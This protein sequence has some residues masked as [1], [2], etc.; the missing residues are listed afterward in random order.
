MTSYFNNGTEFNFFKFLSIL[1]RYTG[2]GFHLHVKTGNYVK[3]LSIN[4]QNLKTELKNLFPFTSHC[5]SK[6]AIYLQ[7]FISE[8][9]K[10]IY[11][12]N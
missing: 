10:S 11:R 8:P 9:A 4:F 12:I 1:A 6:L 2:S 7:R 3:H 5:F